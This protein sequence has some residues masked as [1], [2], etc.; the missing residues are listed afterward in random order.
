MLLHT[1]S[2]RMGVAFILS[3]VY[4]YSSLAMMALSHQL[5]CL[6]VHQSALEGGDGPITS[7]SHK[8]QIVVFLMVFG[9]NPR[10]ISALPQFQVLMHSMTNQNQH[11]LAISGI[12]ARV[13]PQNHPPTHSA[14]TLQPQ[15]LVKLFRHL[16]GVSG[17]NPTL[18][19]L[20]LDSCQHL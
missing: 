13:Q 2:V 16:W 6:G 4:R 9:S 8:T 15:T 14:Q 3:H 7:S 18:P 20:W 12:W 1:E 5:R 11:F 17:V 10:I 19:S